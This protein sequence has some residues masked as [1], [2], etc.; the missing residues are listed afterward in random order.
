[1][2]SE[3]SFLISGMVLGIA[4]S[5]SP[6]PLLT[7]VISETLKYKAKEGIKVAIAPLITDG[8]IILF[9]L[10][11]LNKLADFNF[12]IGTISVFGSLYLTYLAYQ[13]FFIKKVKPQIKDIKSN[14]IRKGVITNFLNPKLLHFTHKNR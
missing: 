14:S 9:I 7:L 4:S 10:L 13:N 11:I 1:M 12:I 3:L 8:P 5:I 2:I 6:G